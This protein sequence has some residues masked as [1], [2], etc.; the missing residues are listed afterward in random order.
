[1][2]KGIVRPAGFLFRTLVLVVFAICITVQHTR[3]QS[4]TSEGP[5][6]PAPKTP[7]ASSQI[8]ENQLVGLPLNGRSYSQLAT[9]E[10]SV[11]DTSA[12]N[13]S[14]GTGGGSL[15]VSG[16]R[17]TSNNFLLDGTNIM[18]SDNKVPRSAAGVQ[19][20]SDAVFQV[21]V[22]SGFVGPEWGRGAGGVLNSITRSGTP[23]LHGTLFEY[24]RNSKLDARNFFDPGTSP[25]PF[26][27]NQFGFTLTGPVKKD[28]T[29]FLFSLEVLRDRLSETQVD[30]FP[31]EEARLGLPDS[32][33]APRAPV[34]PRVVPYLALYPAP[35]SIRLRDGISENRD[36]VFLP[37]NEIFLS[38]RIDHKFSDKD[39]AFIRYTLDNANTKNS[40]ENYLFQSDARS[41]QQYATAV[42]THIFSLAALTALRVGYTRPTS[43]EDSDNDVQ[44][45]PELYFVP[46]GF[47]F[48]L[49]SAPGLS[50]FGPGDS[51]PNINVDNTF[52]FSDDTIIQKGIHTLKF[53]VQV[54][55]YRWDAHSTNG[56]GGQWQFNSLE[57]FL[58]AGPSGTT[59]VATLLG[60]DKSHS[61]RQSLLGLYFQDMI[62][63]RRNLQLSLGLRYEYTSMLTDKN[64][65][66]NHVEDIFHS[67][68]SVFGPFLARNPSGKEFDP[69]VG[70]TWSPGSGK[71]ST[72]SAGFG[73]YHD[74]V[75][76]Y[77]M[78]QRDA[79]Y[80]YYR[81]G[82]QTNIDAR[83]F[84]PN[85]VAAIE[86]HPFDVR[87]L[88]YNHTHVPVVLR[89]TFN[90][91]QQLPRNWRINAGY[92]GARGNHLFRG[93]EAA[94][95]PL[96]VRLADGTLFFPP[97]QGPLNPAFG[98]GV[99]VTSPDAQSFFN[100]LQLS[101]N[102][103]VGQALSFQAS[104]SFSKS[105]DDSS[106]PNMESQYGYERTLN[107]A[108]SDFDFRHRLSL[109]FFYSVPQTL[110]RTWLPSG[111]ANKILGGWRLGGIASIRSGTPF[112]ATVSV[113]T[114]GFLFA[115]TQPDLVP[116]RSPNPSSGESI[117][118]T[119][120]RTLQVVAEPG[121]KLGGAD[122]Y[123]DPCSFAV[124]APGTIGNVGRNTIIGPPLV[125][126]D[127]S[128]QR[129]FSL[130]SKKR[131]QFRA[132]FFNIA[133]H[134]NLGKPL[135]GL[136][137]GVSPGRPNPTAGRITSTNTTSRQI[138]FA[139]RLSF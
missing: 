105:V 30:H 17:A 8:N 128:L 127:V 24:L 35:N 131:L 66:S 60:S 125:N 1:M 103:S 109:N 54:D 31:N 51:F 82:L 79:S 121:Q 117:G 6:Q 19:L 77:V 126:F 129:E 72:I 21:Q 18:D 118:C 92:I 3:G 136:F 5:R 107:R 16:S 73:V 106:T 116:G 100:T 112:T 69:R 59:V 138:Q 61:Y 2:G 36:T 97:D 40:G 111:S 119:D 62:A 10:A 85:A 93:Y 25:P 84:F 80:P 113:R 123:F 132:E 71:S 63:L 120:A 23:Q 114:P 4:E 64:G 134:T 96:P 50:T 41:R 58:Q 137:S 122:L 99:K 102:S 75:L 74:P 68:G 110:G 9:L 42:V 81:R 70:I 78:M 46:G 139:L 26:K 98:G 43:F 12:T 52:Q 34:D 101:A 11:T 83:P 115:A 14:R 135:A 130:D 57:N 67:P 38:T 88:D 15:T 48:G 29:F 95:F 33:G 13:A 22:I 47:R 133:N 90:V 56:A 89:Y 37:T 108:L 91:Q 124:P 65:K 39:S 76:R 7:A 55:R 45:P 44:V 53:G 49:I 87:I 32:T 104:Y 27:R 86:G 20:G 94:L 28:R